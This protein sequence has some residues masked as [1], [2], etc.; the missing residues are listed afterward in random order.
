MKL[1]KRE[2][3]KLTGL[4]TAAVV[5]DP[6]SAAGNNTL[7]DMTGDVSPITPAEHRARI[8]NAQKLMQQ[9]NIDAILMEGGTAMTYFTG[10]RWGRSERL[11]GVVIPRDGEVGIVTPYFEE[12]KARERLPLEAEF[13]TWHEDESPYQRVAELLTDRGVRKGRLGIEETVRFFIADGLRQA[14]PAL[15]I[16]S[17]TPVTLGCRMYKDAHEI[18]LMKKA[19]E[20]TLTAYKHVY[21]RLEAGMTPADVT[22]MMR[23][24]QA[25]LGGEGIWGMAL[26]GQ[27]SAYPHGTNAP[28][29]IREGQIVLMDCGCAVHNY[30]S[31]IS[32]T[33]VFGEA[34]KRQREVW[35]TVRKGLSIVFEAAAIGTPTGEVDDAVRSFYES[36]G[37]GPGYQTPGLSHRTGHGIGMDIHE[38][39]NFVHGETTPLAPGMCLSNEPGLY[40]FD[41]FGVRIEDC[42]YMTADGPNWFTRPPQTI[43]EPMGSFS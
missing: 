2:F 26:F 22:A 17:A 38:S 3:L 8:R 37:Y 4:T 36:L 20:V 35:N 40:N 23:D 27:A 29:S 1:S 33:F 10:M 13:R 41:E 39:V 43:D 19:N 30:R 7:A 11:T 32:R 9:H 34:S 14:A 16:V 42:I 25:A 15:D 5:A 24:A 18:A 12:P 31:D 6:A 28:Q 21:E